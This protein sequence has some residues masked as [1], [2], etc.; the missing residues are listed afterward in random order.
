MNKISYEEFTEVV[1]GISPIGER[2]PISNLTDIIEKDDVMIT[3]LSLC[4]GV[5]VWGG[6]GQIMPF[7]LY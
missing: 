4:S 3:P 7:H 1:Y 5:M 6:C 2:F